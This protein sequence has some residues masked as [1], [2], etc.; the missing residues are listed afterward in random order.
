LVST[1]ITHTIQTV[2][3]RVAFKKS[4]QNFVPFF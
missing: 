3:F 2:L 1:P 4:E